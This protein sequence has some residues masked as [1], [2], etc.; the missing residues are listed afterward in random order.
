MAQPCQHGRLAPEVGDRLLE[1]V[2]V[3]LH[4]AAGHLLDRHRRAAEPGVLGQV[5][6]AHAAARHQS[7]DSVA[8]GQ[9]LCGLEPPGEHP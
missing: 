7:L 4:K 2:G 6:R 5:D 1:G 9:H 3:A 8:P